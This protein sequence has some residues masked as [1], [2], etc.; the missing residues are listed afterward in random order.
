MGQTRIKHRS[1]TIPL[2]PEVVAQLEKQRQLFREKF[3]REPGPNDPVFFDPD[4]AEPKPLDIDRV[5][6]ELAAAMAKAG[7]DPAIQ[8]QDALA[9]YHSRLKGEPS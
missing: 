6:T 3:G 7:I 8:W 2:A 1:R 4:A 9:E 5:E